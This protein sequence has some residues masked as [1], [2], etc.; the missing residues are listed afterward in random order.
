MVGD[1]AA[2][3]RSILELSQP[4]EEGIVKDWD[5]MKLVW[6]RGFDIVYFKLFLNM[7]IIIR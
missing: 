4:V 7:Q 1:E 2:P 6:S 5:D 3:L